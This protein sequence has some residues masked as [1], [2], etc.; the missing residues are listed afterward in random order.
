MVALR[1][2]PCRRATATGT[3]QGVAAAV[4]ALRSIL[5]ICCVSDA[6]VASFVAALG[7]SGLQS[8][9]PT[10]S[11]NLGACAAAGAI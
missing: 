6:E 3:G 8:N 2:G 9:D 1:C 10:S 4:A 7:T 11:P 5:R